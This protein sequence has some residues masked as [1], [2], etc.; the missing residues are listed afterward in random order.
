MGHAAGVRH[1]ALASRTA[2]L[3]ASVVDS[4]V[5][6]G[7]IVVDAVCVCGI[8]VRAAEVGAPATFYL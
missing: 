4:T 5:G 8:G 7:A 2:G 3:S 1:D 6:G